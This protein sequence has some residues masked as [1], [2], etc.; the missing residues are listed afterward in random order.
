MPIEKMGSRPPVN[1]QR[2][3]RV[4]GVKKAPQDFSEQQHGNAEEDKKREERL[5]AAARFNR[6]SFKAQLDAQKGSQAL[7]NR[8]AL[9]PSAANIKK[10]RLSGSISAG[11][12]KTRSLAGSRSDAYGSLALE[13]RLRNQLGKAPQEATIDDVLALQK[14]PTEKNTAANELSSIFAASLPVNE[15][16]RWQQELQK[17]NSDFIKKRIGYYSRFDKTSIGESVREQLRDPKINELFESL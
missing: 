9:I 6:D 14:D 1:F 8:E 12:E 15:I 3:S 4:E 5:S 16:T 7:G 11:Q 13:A 17:G 10:E 2:T